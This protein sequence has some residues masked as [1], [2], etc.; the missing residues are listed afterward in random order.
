MAPDRNTGD[1][2][3]KLRE[4]RERRGIPLRQ[5]AAATKISV[6]VLEALE[7]NDISRL[8]GGIFSRAF[9]RSYATEV[10]LDP[11]A[12]IQEFIA[13][14]PHDTVTA[15]HTPSERIE[16]HEAVE[17][18]RRMASTVLRLVAI[19]VPIAAVVLYFGSA[20]RRMVQNAE[21]PAA[22]DRPES[23]KPS[24]R[25]FEDPPPSA[26][27]PTVPSTPAPPEPP[28]AA[29]A[30]P[31]AAAAL[32]A[33]AS[34]PSP[35][36][37]PDRLTVRLAVKSPCWVSATVDG[38]KSIDRLL[39]AG[40]RQTIDVTREM[41]LTAG[42]AGAIA[43]TLNGADAKALGKAGE[44]VTRRINLSNYKDYLQTR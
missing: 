11:E 4:A 20:G 26:T 13:Q 30:P 40:E 35:A 21:T 37:L 25:S 1:F 39:Q 19:S 7:R 15:G 32:P 43:L 22:A 36:P 27:P 31:R 33:A 3:R 8:P 29:M 6:G 24:P 12:T 14:F 23:P 18:D 9:V 5:I 34:V 10:G 2:G 28:P 38:R 16:D 44:I 42:D 41:V 17:S